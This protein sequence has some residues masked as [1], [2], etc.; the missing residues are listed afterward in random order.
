MTEY[1]AGAVD[2]ETEDAAEGT[3]ALGSN[4]EKTAGVSDNP[5]VNGAGAVCTGAVLGAYTG[6]MRR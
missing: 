3:T 1:R 6:N 4:T 2:T 5:S